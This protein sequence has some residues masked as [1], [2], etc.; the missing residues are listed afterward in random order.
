MGG[1]SVCVVACVGCCA[2]CLISVGRFINISNKST[3]NIYTNTVIY[4]S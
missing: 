2:F 3:K 1:L 4:N